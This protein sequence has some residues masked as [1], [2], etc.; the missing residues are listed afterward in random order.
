MKDNLQA[1]ADLSTVSTSTKAHWLSGHGF[2]CAL[3][4]VVSPASFL[5][6]YDAAYRDCIER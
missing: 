1:T 6:G 5:S 3:E 2:G 4:G